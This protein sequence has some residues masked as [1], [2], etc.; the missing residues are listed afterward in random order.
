MSY[1]REVIEIR[2]I[3]G[4]VAGGHGFAVGGPAVGH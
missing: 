4:V 3:L 2:E 1:G